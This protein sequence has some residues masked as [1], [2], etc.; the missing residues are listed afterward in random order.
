MKK[1][2]QPL[3]SN[4]KILLKNEIIKEQ[5]KYKRFEKTIQNKS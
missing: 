3:K 1:Y 5:E 4:P 2:I